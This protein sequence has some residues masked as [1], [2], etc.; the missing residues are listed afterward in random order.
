MVMGA[1]APPAEQP[2]NIIL[3]GW[4][5]C[6]RDHVKALLKEDKRPNI[7]FIMTDQQFGDAMS[8]R[9]G[10]QYLSTPV[11]DDLAA[12]GMLFTRAYSANPL[13]MPLRN[14]LFTG[15]Y[16]R[17]IGKV[18]ARIGKV[19]EALRKAGQEDRTLIVLTSDHGECAG[20]HGFNQKTVL[21]E[22]SARVPLVISC[23]GK[24]APGVL[25]QS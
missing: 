6:H 23:K 11:M 5:G 1:E 21:Y 13:C 14:S 22:E 2:Q 19:L 17:M 12:G 8:C 10:K 9:M 15:R 25:R 3:M 7:L 24:T 4:D 20:A 16:Y 18:D